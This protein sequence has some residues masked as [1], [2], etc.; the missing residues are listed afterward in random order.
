M[1]TTSKFKSGGIIL[2]FITLTI[3]ILFGFK[4]LEKRLNSSEFNLTNKIN[5][6]KWANIKQSGEGFQPNYIEENITQ[7]IDEINNLISDL[8]KVRENGESEIVQRQQ[9]ELILLIHKFP[10]PIDLE[11]KLSNNFP[12]LVF[13]E[14][15]DDD[16]EYSIRQTV[17]NNQKYIIKTQDNNELKLDLHLPN[18]N[19]PS[20]N[21][22]ITPGGHH[23][24][25]KPS[26]QNNFVKNIDDWESELDKTFFGDDDNK[27]KYPLLSRILYTYKYN[28]IDTIDKFDIYKYLF[29]NGTKNTNTEQGNN[30][31]YVKEFINNIV[32]LFHPNGSKFENTYKNIVDPKEDAFFN[33]KYEPV[34]PYYRILYTGYD[35]N[36]PEGSILGESNW[37]LFEEKDTISGSIRRNNIL[38]N[39]T[40]VLETYASQTG[41]SNENPPFIFKKFD[42]INTLKVNTTGINNKKL[43]KVIKDFQEFAFN[44]QGVTIINEFR[45]QISDTSKRKLQFLADPI[46]RLQPIWPLKLPGNE[47]LHKSKGPILKD[48]NG[49]F[50]TSDVISID[51]SVKFFETKFIGKLLSKIN[52]HKKVFSGITFVYLSLSIYYLI[53][54]N[55]KSKRKNNE[56]LVD[57][58]KRT[59]N[60][61]TTKKILFILFPITYY[62]FALFA[63]VS[64]FRWKQTNNPNSNQTD[65]LINLKNME[66]VSSK[67]MGSSL[68]TNKHIDIIKKKIS[69]YEDL[70]IQQLK[71]QSYVS[72]GLGI[73][74]I[75]FMLY[76]IL[77]LFKQYPFESKIASIT[78]AFIGIIGIGGYLL[79][80]FKDILLA[81]VPKNLIIFG[82][83][84]PREIITILII[85]LVL[86]FILYLLFSNKKFIKL[87]TNGKM[88]LETET[89]LSNQKRLGKININDKFCISSWFYFVANSTSNSSSYKNYSV[90]FNFNWNPIMM[91]NTQNGNL[92]IIFEDKTFNQQIV[93]DSPIELQ[94][95]NNI[96]INYDGSNADIFINSNLVAT[97]KNIYIDN[98]LSYLDVGN[99]NNI[100]SK[101]C[102]I[103][104]SSILDASC[105]SPTDNIRCLKDPLTSPNKENKIVCEKDNCRETVS[106]D[107]GF[108]SENINGGMA[109]IVYYDNI[110]KLG[111]INKNYE[112][113]NQFLKNKVY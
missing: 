90:F 83:K 76:I 39:E 108:S 52:N 105:N 2:S 109:N 22:Y 47:K 18:I 71:F 110:L 25:L 1:T 70:S 28:N 56:S 36:N 38:M 17:K 31:M 89:N 51:N 24:R 81:F 11:N 98:K 33:G 107:C 72:S 41:G 34:D 30:K 87:T 75:S 7:D 79:F 65:M 54:L 35:Y 50:T 61:N 74:S 53:Y 21:K 68:F 45:D 4:F 49:S 102:N 19:Q 32:E 86:L 111:E 95:W 88:L 99:I 66:S 82:T 64:Y 97:K 9:Q 77:Q 62:I 15:W 13:K 23:N 58:K 112:V 42:N 16:S 96:V 113:F 93:Y 46:T 37:P 67:H 73:F 40:K 48:T 27:S 80:K 63:I 44:K 101:I 26:K 29:D 5:T 100:N 103:K 55:N 60:T 78:I 10:N 85:L 8:N 3:I 92:K 12:N 104:N 43:S 59:K 94:K 20:A 84:N 14:N 6:I 91:I 57:Y 106:S 69:Y